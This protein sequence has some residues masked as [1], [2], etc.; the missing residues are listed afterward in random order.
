M[1]QSDQPQVPL[2]SRTARLA[3]FS[4]H[5][6]TA[7]G[8][9]VALIALLEAVRQ[10][11]AAMFAWLGL[12]LVIDGVD[13]PMARRLDVMRVQPDWSGEVLD[14]VV[15]FVTYVFVPAYA[16]A[17]S[18]LLLPFTS[19]LLGAGIVVTSALYFADRRMK[20]LDNHF[21]G[22]PALWNAA[23]FYLFLLHPPPVLASLGVAA[24]I[25]LTFVPLHVIHPVR[26]A[27]LRGLNLALMAIWAVLAIFALA[28]DFDVVA[29]VSIGLCAI[30]FYVI[31][32]DAL[33][34][35]LKPAS[36]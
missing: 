21:R 28:Q 8:A 7:L 22:F 4:V 1:S 18:G 26:V 24:L 32:A 31:G 17:A 9:G 5:I 13:G 30:A 36:A 16:I 34:R 12:A 33:I 29:P 20:T 6:F 11:W 25:V 2:A 10:H 3:A 23:A 14:L 35:L 27:R 19:Q 15:D